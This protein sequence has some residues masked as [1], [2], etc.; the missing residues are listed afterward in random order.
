MGQMSKPDATFIKNRKRLFKALVHN[1]CYLFPIKRYR[2]LPKGMWADI[3]TND[4][5]TI[6]AW[7]DRKLNI[8]VDTGK[9]KLLVIDIDPKV[10]SADEMQDTLELLYEELPKTFTVCTASGGTHLYFKAPNNSLGNTAGGLLDHVDTRGYGG[11]VV[12][13]GSITLDKDVANNLLV[14]KTFDVPGKGEVEYLD[15]DYQTLFNEDLDWRYYDRASPGKVAFA[16]L[17]QAFI[18]KLTEV[19]QSPTKGVATEV[20]EEDVDSNQ[21]IEGAIDYCLHRQIGRAHV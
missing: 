1:G 17:P 15:F 11:Y 3:S 8:G 14:T 13:P 7:I 12:G 20:D 4:W 9:S 16:D 2:K 6:E 21:A 5:N 19:A 10:E 18:D